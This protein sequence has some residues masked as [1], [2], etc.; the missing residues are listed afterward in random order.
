MAT[1]RMAL[2]LDRRV[3]R[4]CKDSQLYTGHGNARSRGSARLPLIPANGAPALFGRGKADMT[5]LRTYW[6]SRDPATFKD[7]NVFS[8][9]CQLPCKLSQSDYMTNN[10][11]V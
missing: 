3:R 1:L 8:G 4:L 10:I 7:G 6:V 9:G 2:V 5:Y 11:V